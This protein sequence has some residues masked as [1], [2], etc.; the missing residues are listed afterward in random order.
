ML[1]LLITMQLTIFFENTYIV[2]AYNGNIFPAGNVK[3]R[4][5]RLRCEICSKLTIKT[6]EMVTTQR[7]KYQE[8]PFYPKIS[9]FTK[10]SGKTKK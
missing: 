4:N 7:S 1:Q 5:I 10:S 3:N 6:T 8:T 9:A 2:V